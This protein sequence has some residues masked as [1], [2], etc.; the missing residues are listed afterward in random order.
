VGV[1]GAGLGVGVANTTGVEVLAGWVLPRLSSP[2]PA[3]SGGPHATKIRD[4]PNITI[5]NSNF[6][7]FLY[8]LQVIWDYIN[9]L[10]TDEFSKVEYNKSYYFQQTN[11]DFYVSVWQVKAK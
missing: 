11:K 9:Y 8:L 4:S 7:I 2:P 5:N 10:W 1:G 3:C 6:F